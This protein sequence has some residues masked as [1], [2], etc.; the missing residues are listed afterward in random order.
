MIS[1]ATGGSWSI[2]I[3]SMIGMAATSVLGCPTVQRG[4]RTHDGRQVHGVAGQ[5]APASERWSV[6]LL[7]ARCITGPAGRVTGSTSTSTSGDTVDRRSPVRKGAEVAKA[8]KVDETKPAP[9][10]TR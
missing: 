6:V 4:D 7:Y 5:R 2:G 1:R 3:G 10:Q 8:A 9:D